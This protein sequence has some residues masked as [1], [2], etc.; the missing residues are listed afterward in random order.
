[1]AKSSDSLI[2]KD[3]YVQGS[4]RG[5]LILFRDQIYMNM[6]ALLIDL[7]PDGLKAQQLEPYGIS[8]WGDAGAFQIAV[9]NKHVDVSYTPNFPIHRLMMSAYEYFNGYIEIARIA[10]ELE[11][12]YAAHTAHD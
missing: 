12:E 6:Q 11:N 5:D 7:F 8:Y 1:M 4:P 2:N 3:F 10:V 9:F